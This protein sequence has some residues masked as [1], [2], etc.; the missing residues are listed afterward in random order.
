MWIQRDRWIQRK[1]TTLTVWIQMNSVD[2]EGQVDTEEVN[3]VD[4]MD[5]DE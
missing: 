3:H 5:T 1:S 2:T 4:S